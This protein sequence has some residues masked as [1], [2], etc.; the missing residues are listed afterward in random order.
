M[1]PELA[2][3]LS[4]L[5]RHPVNSSALSRGFGLA[6]LSIS[7]SR[8][9]TFQYFL[10]LL[11]WVLRFE[12]LPTPDSALPTGVVRF[13]GTMAS[14]DSLQT[15]YSSARSR[16]SRVSQDKARSFH[17]V[18]AEFTMRTLDRVSGVSIHCCLTSCALAFYSVLVHPV[19]VSPPASSPPHIAVTQLPFAI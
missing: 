3:L 2:T 14:A 19:C 6:P 17:T 16:Y 7:Q 12:W 4:L 11:L 18:Q 9:R 8:L 13:G 1:V 15:N 10:A 5:A